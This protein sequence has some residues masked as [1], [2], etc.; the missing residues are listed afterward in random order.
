MFKIIFWISIILTPT[1]T[2]YVKDELIFL[3]NR[4]VEYYEGEVVVLP[5]VMLIEDKQVKAIDIWCRKKIA[6]KTT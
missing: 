2:E 6:G 4:C 3:G 1:T 5:S